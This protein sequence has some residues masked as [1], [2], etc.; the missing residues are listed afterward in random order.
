MTTP[1]KKHILFLDSFRALTAIY[2]VAHHVALHYFRDHDMLTGFQKM[3]IIFLNYGPFAV[4]LFIVLSGYSLMLS[5]TKNNYILKGGIVEFIKRRAIR[6]LPPY[7]IAMCFSIILIWLLVGTKTNTHWDGSVPVTYIDVVKHVLL[8]HDFTKSSMFTINHVFWSIAVE[9]RIYLFFPLLVLVWKKSGFM[10]S[11]FLSVV[12]AVIGYVFLNYLQ[13]YYGSDIDTTWSGVTPYIILF[14]LGMIASDFAFSTNKLQ[15][16]ARGVFENSTVIKHLSLT[17]ILLFLCIGFIA[18]VKAG[19]FSN[20][21]YNNCKQIVSGVVFAYLLFLC[22]IPGNKF[23]WVNKFLHF[24]PFVFIGTFSFSLYL[25]HAPLIQ[26]LSQYVFEPMG[27]S[28]F[29]ITLLLLFVG[30]PV[31]IGVSY[32]FFLCFEKPFLTMGKNVSKSPV[33]TPVAVTE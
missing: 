22:A 33:S 10:A 2:V 19:H 16:K 3:F 15:V 9:F 24:K 21:L 23:V 4:N 17:G 6:I 25:I 11:L 26:V 32:I 14:T 18:L 13:G 8:I 30:L 12:I 31:I 29:T 1:Q 20:Y 28:K 5:I 7:Y 27:F